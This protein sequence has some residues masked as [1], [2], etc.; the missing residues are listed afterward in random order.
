MIFVERFL[1][2]FLCAGMLQA[3]GLAALIAPSTWAT[4]ECPMCSNEIAMAGEPLEIDIEQVCSAE[5]R[6]SGEC[7][8]YLQPSVTCSGVPC[9]FSA[10]FLGKWGT[11]RVLPLAAGDMI[12]N[13]QLR[14]PLGQTGHHEFGPIRVVDAPTQIETLCW[15]R[16]GGD[17]TYSECGTPIAPGSDLRVDVVAVPRIPSV[18]RS[19]LAVLFDGAPASASDWSCARNAAASSTSD[20]SCFAHNIKPGNHVLRLMLGQASSETSFDVQSR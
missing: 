14:D 8:H 3:C 5:D 9:S 4:A 6:S 7:E 13:L 19:S 10:E 15:S 18:A 11:I 1:F 17:D 20:F 16:R 2:A 12:I